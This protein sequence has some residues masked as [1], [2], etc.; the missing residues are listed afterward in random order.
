MS[1]EPRLPPTWK[2]RRRGTGSESR[3]NYSCD[4]YDC[5]PDRLFQACFEAV[6]RLNW[7]IQHTDAGTRTLSCAAR[8]SKARLGGGQELSL[9]VQP[10]VRSHETGSARLVLGWGYQVA[11]VFDHGEKRDITRLLID[12]LDVV[13]PRVPEPQAATERNTPVAELERLAHLHSLGKLTDEEFA[14]AKAQ[15]LRPATD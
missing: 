2:K 12:T 13:L 7:K 8:G 15:V 14:S 3:P 10:L 9:V 11:R 6:T 5:S 1:E 4:F